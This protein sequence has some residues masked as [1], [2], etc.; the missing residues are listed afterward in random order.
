[1]IR[2][3]WY[4]GKSHDIMMHAHR[5]ECE[6][7]AKAGQRVRDSLQSLR[8]WTEVVGRVSHNDVFIHTQEWASELS[9]TSCSDLGGFETGLN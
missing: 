9:P 3:M 6:T 7:F 5:S 2:Y 1:M 4:L 8:I